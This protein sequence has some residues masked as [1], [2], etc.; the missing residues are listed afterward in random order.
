MLPYQA[1]ASN[2]S[3]ALQAFQVLDEIFYAVSPFTIILEH[4]AI[5]AKFIPVNEVTGGT[6]AIK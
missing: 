2:C 4:V 3:P 5:A 6:E 1:R